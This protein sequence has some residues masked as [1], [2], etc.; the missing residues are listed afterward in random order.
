MIIGLTGKNAAGKGEALKYLTE[1]GFVAHSLSDVIRDELDAVGK[2]ITRENLVEMGNYLRQK[3]GPAVLALMIIEKIDPN[4]NF[5]IDSIR[6]P[7]EV[8]ALQKSSSFFLVNIESKPEIRFERIKSRDRENDPMTLDEFRK[9]EDI[10][11]TSTDMAHQNIEACQKLADFIVH[12]DKTIENFQK[13][14]LETIQKIMVKI[15]R[16]SWDEYFMNITKVVASRGNCVKRKVAAVI[17]KDRRIISSGYNGTPRGTTNCNEGGC[18]RCFNLAPTGEDL[19]ECLCSHAE[20][21]AITQAAYHGTSVKGST[22]YITLAPCLTCTK[23]IINSGI[24]EIVYN[25]DYMFDDTSFKLCTE[26]GV[27][28]RKIKA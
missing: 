26:A 20:E 24:D 1:R 13:N 14:L 6:N 23:M 10:E 7:F 17:V 3:G 2:E 22:I 5:V 4:R 21:N 16:P 11:A 12:N 28:V 9:F 15:P 25:I 18:P 27:K 19:S 8:E